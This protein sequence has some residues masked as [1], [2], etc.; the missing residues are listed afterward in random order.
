M[1]EERES[2]D[3]QKA[4]TFFEYGNDAALKGNHDYAI[5]MYKQACSIDVENLV[6]RQALRGIETAEVRQR[7]GQGRHAGRCQ[8]PAAL[9]AGAG[10]TLETE[11][12][13]SPR[14]V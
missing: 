7:P 10:C 2:R 8:E 5:A 14:A 1:S 6:Y 11:I 4:K 9:V 12:H 3:L 13:G